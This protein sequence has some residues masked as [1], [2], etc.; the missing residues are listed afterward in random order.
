MIYAKLIKW[1]VICNC[2]IHATKNL[3]KMEKNETHF[4]IRDLY[5][6]NS[7]RENNE[8]VKEK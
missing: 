3:S 5:T 4:I 6:R 1:K 8:N 7:T 2:V